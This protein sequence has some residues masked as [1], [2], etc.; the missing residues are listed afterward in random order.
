MAGGLKDKIQSKIEI[1]N[2]RATFD[3]EAVERYSAG[4]VLTGTEIKSI[5]Q[6]KASLQEAYCTFKGHELIILNMHIAPYEQGTWLNHEPRRERK[7]LLTKKEL[8]KLKTKSEE[9]GLAIIPTRLFIND[10]GLAKLDIMLGRGKK[11]YD[12]REDIKEKDV[13]RQLDR[14]FKI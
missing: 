5:R 10:K 13:K 3:Y 8:K 7:L 4:M 11:L 2:K 14:S 1:K 6:G 12:K 9:K